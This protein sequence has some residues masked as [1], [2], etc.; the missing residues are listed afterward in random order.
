M[1][2]SNTFS[3]QLQKNNKL[4]LNY[5]EVRLEDLSGMDAELASNISTRPQEFLAL[6]SEMKI[7]VRHYCYLIANKVV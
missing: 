7:I 5:I 4:S 2:L 6:V 1:S 3:E